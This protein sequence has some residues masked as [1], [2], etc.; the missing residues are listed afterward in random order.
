MR[1]RSG[2]ILRSIEKAITPNTI[3]IVASAVSDG[4]GVLDPIEQIGA[5]A[6]RHDLLFH[7]D[8]CIGGFLL[9]YYKRL[10]V[11][12]GA[13]DFRVPGVT[14]M[15]MDWHKYAYCPERAVGHPAPE[16]GAATSPDFRNGRVDGL[17]DHQ[18]HDPVVQDRRSDGGGLGSAELSWR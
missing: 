5:I 13:F 10:G 16:Q 7:V 12:L 9:P 4:H 3:Q 14:S 6:Q 11:P 18:S 8:G 17:Y 15:S 2:P 1:H